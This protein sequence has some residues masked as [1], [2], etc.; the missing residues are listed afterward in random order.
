MA[1]LQVAGVFADMFTYA[2]I[3]RIEPLAQRNRVARNRASVAE[4]GINSTKPNRSRKAVSSKAMERSAV[5]MVPITRTLA[6]TKT[7]RQTKVKSLPARACFFRAAST[8]RQKCAGWHH[9]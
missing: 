1:D 2:R 4:S 6:G 3:Q 7:C 8:T 5:F 9:D